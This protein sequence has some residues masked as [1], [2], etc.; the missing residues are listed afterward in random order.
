MALFDKLDDALKDNGF[1]SDEYYHMC[2]NDED[3]EIDA[4]VEN[5]LL[6]N[7]ATNVKT[8]ITDAFESCGYDRS[9]LSIA[10]I[11]AEGLHLETILIESM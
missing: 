3:C 10:W 5:F 2:G 1:Y 6:K 4:F 11:D 9:V 7:D 8:D